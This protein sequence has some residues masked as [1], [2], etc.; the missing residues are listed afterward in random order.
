M[1]RA[2]APPHRRR[3]GE[4]M[5]DEAQQDR[6]AT[7]LRQAG[8]LLVT[9]DQLDVGEALRRDLRGDLVEVGLVNL[10]GEHAAAGAHHSSQVQGEASLSGSHVGDTH[11]GSQGQGREDLSRLVNRGVGAQG[12]RQREGQVRCRPQRALF[13]SH[14]P[15]Y[16]STNSP[17]SMSL[18]TIRFESGNG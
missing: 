7:A 16:P 11:A 5:V 4:V 3:L 2:S 15:V 18:A 8:L 6:V 1:R 13:R 9:Q 10:G 17:P 12:R 14:E